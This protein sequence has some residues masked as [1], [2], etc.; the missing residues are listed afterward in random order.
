M[1]IIRFF[2]ASS[3][4]LKD[5]R[6]KFAA[7]ISRLN[8]HYEPHGYHFILDI[9]EFLNPVYNNRRKQDEYNDRI[10]NS[11]VFLA[12]FHTK[13]GTYTLEELKIAR[14]ESEKRSLPMFIYFK[15]LNFWQKLL[16]KDESL[17]EVKDYITNDL[18]HYWGGYNNNDK[19]HLDFVLW[20]DNWLN[21]NSAITVKDNEVNIGFMTI[22]QFSQLPFAANNEEYKWL[23]EQLTVLKQEIEQLSLD[24]KEHPENEVSSV[25]L[26]QKILAHEKLRLEAQR[27]Q[28]AMLESAKRIAELRRQQI[29]ETL[30]LAVEEFVNGRLSEANGFLMKLQEEGDR[31]FEEIEKKSGIF[32][33]KQRQMHE[34]IEALLLQIQIIMADTKVP[35][36]E[37]VTQIESLY[38]KADRWALISNYDEKKY[39]ELLFY[40]ADFLCHCA[41][42]SN[43]EQ[44]FSRQIVLSEKLYGKN[45]LKTAISYFAIGA[46][47]IY[48]CDYSQALNYN[49]KALVIRERVLGVENCVTSESYNNIGAIYYNKSDYANALVFYEK[50]RIVEEI[51]LGKDHPTLASTYNNIG[52]VYF[53]QGLS[54]QALEA[55]KKALAISERSLGEDDTIMAQVINNIGLVYSRQGNHD[56]A[57]ECYFKSLAIN[58]RTVGKEHPLTAVNYSN[59]G[60][61]YL[62]KGDMNHALEFYYKSFAIHKQ[63][64]GNNHPDMAVSYQ[65][66][67]AVYEKQGDYINALNCYFKALVIQERILGIHPDTASSYHSIGVIYHQQN[68]I[69]KALEY[70]FKALAIRQRVFGENH[71]DTATSYNNIGGV[72]DQI[73]D[74]SKALE[75]YHKALAIVE[76]VLGAHPHTV[77]TLTN[78]GRIFKKRGEEKLALDYFLKAKAIS[79]QFFG[80]Q[81]PSKADI[82]DSIGEIYIKLGNYDKALVYLEEAALTEESLGNGLGAAY[83]YNN[84]GRVYFL[85]SNFD[86]ALEYSGKA[87]SIYNAILGENDPKTQTVKDNIEIVRR[88]MLG[89]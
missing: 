70:Y 38:N 71:S 11:D 7:F 48:L 33:T 12:L 82:Y 59:I 17:K 83:V 22:A 78:I 32:E 69:D 57:L 54:A 6:E 60:H 77:A 28:E 49:F 81:Y 23:D 68:Y 3:S 4:E 74:Y 56:K 47:Y 87:Y 85:Q 39:A 25:R 63:I 64:W 55:F 45:H 50:T 42:Y 37:C 52:M 21:Q 40:Y 73:G 86:K 10:R 89:E 13:A 30:E 24:V 8:S 51:L 5:D 19:L 35:L 2:L 41:R 72:Y 66:F 43:A 14:E 44:V 18:E 80:E 62:D 15:D 26:S 75:F 29:S 1:K 65:N 84:I 20:L 16:K 53:K 46:V 34:H 31:L 88:Q 79:E 9:W 36:K 61:T 67:G 76:I 58:E 27:Q